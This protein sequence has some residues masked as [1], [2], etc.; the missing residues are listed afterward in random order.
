M[1]VYRPPDGSVECFFETISNLIENH[2]LAQ[3]ELWIV[4][5]YIIDFLKRTDSKTK[6][7]FE[8]LRINS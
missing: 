5:D 3:I 6:K 4:G 2:S 7:L 1:T 8:F